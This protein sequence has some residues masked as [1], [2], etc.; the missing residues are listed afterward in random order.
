MLPTQIQNATERRCED[1]NSRQ[2]G[3]LEDDLHDFGDNVIFRDATGLAWVH[4]ETYRPKAVPYCAN[5][6]VPVAHKCS[7]NPSRDVGRPR[8]FQILQRQ[9]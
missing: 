9:C 6:R 7:A 8:C 3:Q 1:D 5:V 2:L 4:N